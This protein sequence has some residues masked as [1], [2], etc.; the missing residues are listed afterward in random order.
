MT[1]LGRGGKDIT[2]ENGDEIQSDIQL[3]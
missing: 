1:H 2:Q 3:K